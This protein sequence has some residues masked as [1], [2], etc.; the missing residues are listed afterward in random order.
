MK[1]LGITGTSGSGKS[2]FSEILGRREDVRIIDADKV[3]KELSL[4]DSDYLNDIVN[5]FGK[6]ILLEDGNLNRKSLA[7]IIYNN[8]NK[9][10]ILNSITFPHIKKE[11]YKRIK[12]FAESKVQFVIIDAPLLFEAG[13]EKVCDNIISLLTSEELQVRRICERDGISE[14]TAK[15]RLCSQKPANYYIENSDI[16]I[17]NTENTDLKKEAE[18][19]FKELEGK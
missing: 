15:A 2:T 11:I 13:L 1:I 7:H 5:V 19:I 18:K 9:R 17:M 14:E 16:I 12:K 6:D 8:E 3:A 10:N 4:P